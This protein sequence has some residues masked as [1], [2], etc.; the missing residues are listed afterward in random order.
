MG[1]SAYWREAVHTVQIK[2]SMLNVRLAPLE[3]IDG[4]RPQ[5][6]DGIILFKIHK[7]GQM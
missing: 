6:E 1:A 2:Q 7:S 5:P 3:G 4:V